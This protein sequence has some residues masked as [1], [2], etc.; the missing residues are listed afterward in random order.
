MVAQHWRPGQ[1]AAGGG[2]SNRDYPMTYPGAGGFLP[3]HLRAKIL[4]SGARGFNSGEDE[5]TVLYSDHIPLYGNAGLLGKCYVFKTDNTAPTVAETA[6][7]IV[8]EWEYAPPDAANVYDDWRNFLVYP[9]GAGAGVIG[10]TFAHNINDPYSINDVIWGTFE[11]AAVGPTPVYARAKLTLTN[12]KS[13]IPLYM[14]V[15]VWGNLSVVR[16]SQNPYYP[17]SFAAF[18]H[19]DYTHGAKRWD[20]SASHLRTGFYSSRRTAVEG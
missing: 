9:P 4:L 15:E 7:T 5:V 19:K 1:R 11:S 14:G 2:A 12:T 6:A 16:N 10:S 17:Y 8:G 3:A 20:L 18:T 13:S